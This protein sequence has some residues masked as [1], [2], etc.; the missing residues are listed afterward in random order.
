MIFAE[1]PSSTHP[2]PGSSHPLI[3]PHRPHLVLP[4]PV[5]EEEVEDT[6]LTPSQPSEPPSR[7]PAKED[8]PHL[9]FE[10]S[11]DDGFYVHSKSIEG[12]ICVLVAHQECANA[13]Q[14]N[15]SLLSRGGQD[16]LT[17]VECMG[18]RAGRYY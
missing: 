5:L 6:P 14:F 1:V 15:V 2:H 7:P 10:I 9:L 4:F 3:H 13:D 8:E 18:T 16:A 17:S 12:E 11:S